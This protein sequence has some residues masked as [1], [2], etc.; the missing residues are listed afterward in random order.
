MYY[1]QHVQLYNVNKVK[2]TYYTMQFNLNVFTILNNWSKLLTVGALA[3]LKS[4]YNY[5]DHSNF[6]PRHCT[7]ASVQSALLHRQ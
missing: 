2:R 4:P 6:D 5:F 7:I 1:V 3:F